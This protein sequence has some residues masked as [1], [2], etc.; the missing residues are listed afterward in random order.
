MLETKEFTLN[1]GKQLNVTIANWKSAVQ[2]A[3]SI[4]KCLRHTGVNMTQKEFMSLD[5][6]ALFSSPNIVQIITNTAL[7]VFIDDNIDKIFWEMATKC[8]YDGLRLTED[9]FN[10]S[11][12]ARQDFYQVKFIVLR[13]NLLPFF[14]K[15][16]T[17][18]E[19]Q[20]TGK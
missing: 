4:L 6:G 13:E 16:R 1:S 19:E 10:N 18:L 17:T 9:V 7:E 8:T 14:P 20:P 3:Q 2:L 15:L 11:V 12:E 5:F